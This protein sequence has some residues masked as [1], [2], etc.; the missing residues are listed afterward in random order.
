MKKPQKNSL[1]VKTLEYLKDTS[2]NLLDLSVDIV[3]NPEEIVGGL[4]QYRGKKKYYISREIS[5]LKNSSYFTAK[6][7]KIYLTEKG[8]IEIIKNIIK[9]K[10]KIEKWSGK[11]W[12]IIF[13]I[14]E[15]NR[16][17]RSFLRKELKWLKFKELQHSVWITPC[18]IE[19]E[20]LALLKLWKR[21]FRGDIRF[22]RIEKIIHDKDI[23]RFFDL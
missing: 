21:D 9:D 6:N 1:I 23:K 11:W 18:D 7:S 10:K 5:H 8:R 3:F 2:K 12:A 19:K 14:P 4:I 16:K 22:L 13:D 17:E 15:I 20:L